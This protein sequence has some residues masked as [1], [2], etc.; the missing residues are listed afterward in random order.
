MKHSLPPEMRARTHSNLI[1]VAFGMLLLGVLVYLKN[2]FAGI[3]M[4]LGVVTPFLI[5]IGLAFLQLP[6]VR[7]V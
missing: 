7:N 3:N 6:I 2:I 4:L 1:V 5:G